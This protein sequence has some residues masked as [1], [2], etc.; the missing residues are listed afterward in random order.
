MGMTCTQ[1]PSILAKALFLGLPLTCASVISYAAVP[2]DLSHEN[3]FMLHSLTST[4]SKIDE[5][6]RTV[7]FNKTLHVRVQQTYRNY[8]VW[9]ADGV[10][11]YKSNH[12]SHLKGGHDDSVTMNG[13]MYRDMDADLAKTPSV[14]FTSAHAD[15]AIAKT[16]GTYQQNVGGKPAIHNSK[17]ELIVFVDDANKAHYA[18]KVSF[19]AEPLKDGALPSKPNFIVDAVTFKVYRSW[20]EIQTITADAV[21]GGGFG[22]NKKM[23]ELAYDGLTGDLRK[24]AY[25]RDGGTCTL[26]N[27][28]VTVKHSGSRT[29][30]EFPCDATNPDHDNIYWSGELHAVNGGYSPDNDALFGGIIIKEMYQSWYG[31]PVLIENGKPMMLNMVV[32]AH[33]DNAY[34]DGKQMTFGD[35]ISMFYP[36]TSLGV[37]SHEISHGFTQQHSNLAY[38]GQSGGM[39]EAFSD[40]AAQGAEYFAYG[41]NSWQIGPE[42]FKAPNE[43]LRYM[44]KPSKDCRGKKPGNW[45]SI[46]SADQYRSGLDVHFSSGVYNRVFYLIGT[47]ANWDTRKAFDIMVQANAN[48]WT[49]G[50]TFVQGACGV[51]SAAKDYKYDTAAVLEAF[52]TV[53]I[54]TSSC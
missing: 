7:D 47:A 46:D 25:T 44:D 50:T 32:H 27:A 26:A 6:S 29:A 37:A 28:D 40:M 11:H 24:L 52:K 13:T 22:G 4:T 36:L 30:V 35:G 9:G 54:D 1:R 45:C 39:N 34:W 49:S 3:P 16:I 33:M 48:Y 5:V 8:P 38:Y 15:Q 17:S 51:I 31:V 14:V 53:G 43:A 42:I 10:V 18:Y 12:T 41:K 20:D 21:Q 19:D 2:V 23:G